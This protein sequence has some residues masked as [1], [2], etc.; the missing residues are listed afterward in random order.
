MALLSSNPAV[1]ARLL[2]MA[3]GVATATAAGVS[4]SCLI[5]SNAHQTCE[6]LGAPRPKSLMQAED[7][8]V[9]GVQSQ[10]WLAQEWNGRVRD[11]GKG[12]A[13]WF[14]SNGL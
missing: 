3:L 5:W 13:Q 8:Q 2:G 1:Q 6:V 4:I 9:W 7:R 11:A 10:A 12:V 14:A